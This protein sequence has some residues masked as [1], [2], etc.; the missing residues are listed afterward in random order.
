MSSTTDRHEIELP[1]GAVFPDWSVV[2]APAAEEA[3]LSILGVFGAQERHQDLSLESD[4]VRRAV[5]SQYA[6]KGEAPSTAEVAASAALPVTIT[7]A[8]LEDLEQRDLLVR[9]DGQI[10]GAYPFTSRTTEHRVSVGEVTVHAMCA[11]DALGV[12]AMLGA[13]VEIRS[14]C[15][16]CGQ[17]IEL[18]TEGGGTLL[19]AVPTPPLVWAGACYQDRAATSLCTVIAFFC[20][21]AHLATWQEERG[22]ETPGHRLSLQEAFQVGRAIFAP[23]LSGDR[24]G[25]GGGT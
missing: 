3:L 16:H 10:I 11:I 8:A 18:S 23:R 12:G 19:H 1:T 22:Q 20:D 2:T 7:E 9:E 6:E 17:P 14:S 4:A 13:D 15:R 21:E 5:I 24:A 25:G